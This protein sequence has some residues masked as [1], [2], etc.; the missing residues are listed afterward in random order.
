MEADHHPLEHLDA[1]LAA[2]DNAH[3][4][5]NR[6]SNLDLRSALAAALQDFV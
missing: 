5:A 3:V 1:L 6:V 2:L 4:H